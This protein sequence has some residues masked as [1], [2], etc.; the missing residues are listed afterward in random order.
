MVA[1]LATGRFRT[2]ASRYGWQFAKTIPDIGQNPMSGI[3]V[4][5]GYC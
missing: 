1:N 2:N 5:T 3:F 4:L